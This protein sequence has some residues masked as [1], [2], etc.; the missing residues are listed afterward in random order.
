MA[1]ATQGAG[2]STLEYRAVIACD[3][4]GNNPVQGTLRSGPAEPATTQGLTLR[5]GLNMAALERP[6]TG[7]AELP[8][9][10]RL[11]WQPDSS[12]G[13][14]PPFAQALQLRGDGQDFA[15]ALDA[16]SAPRHTVASATV[17]L[18]DG[19]HQVQCSK[20]EYLSL[21]MECDL[22]TSAAVC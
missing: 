8:P 3:G 9:I 7:A 12:G 19:T 11:F 5:Q 22:A 21:E 16:T 18:L 4:L 2:G 13:P 1:S 17:T 14:V 15:I 6:L 10:D 20:F